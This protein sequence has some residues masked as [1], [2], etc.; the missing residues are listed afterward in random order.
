MPLRC[1]P[2]P[3]LLAAIAAVLALS[4][5][6]A[7]AAAPSGRSRLTLPDGPVVPGQL[8][9]VTWGNPAGT[10]DEMELILSLDGGRTWPIRVSRDL[11]PDATHASFRVPALPTAEARLALRAGREGEEEEEEEIV[12]ESGEFPILVPQGPYG[13]NL[14]RVRGEWRTDEARGGHPPDLP[15]PALS[16]RLRIGAG[17]ANGSDADENAGGVD[18]VDATWRRALPPTP[19]ARPSRTR[20]VFRRVVLSRRE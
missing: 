9:S 19:P 17:R 10:W 8:L 18:A 12:A 4:A 20:D 13:E 6:A 15:A 5:V 1:R 7:P 2:I 14:A 3:A 11:P 16:G